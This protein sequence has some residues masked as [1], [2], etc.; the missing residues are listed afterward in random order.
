MRIL[1]FVSNKP[2]CIAP[3]SPYEDR[4]LAALATYHI[5]DTPLEAD[6]DDLARLAA[7][8]CDAPIAL[9]SLVDA[10]RQW[11]KAHYGLDTTETPREHAFCAHAILHPN[12]LMVVPDALADER[13]WDNP[14]VTGDPGIRFYAGTPLVTPAGDAV[15]VLCV[16]GHTPRSLTPLQADV[17]QTLGRQVLLLLEQRRAI[18]ELAAAEAAI[19]TASQRFQ[20]ILASLYGGILVV[21]DDQRVEF[22]NQAFCDLFNLA[23]GPEQLL[24]W[25]A[26]DI[27]QR[28]APIYSDT[29]A[30]LARIQAIVASGQPVRNEEVAITGG[31]TYLRDFIPIVLDGHPHG[32]AWHHLDITDRKEA[33]ATLQHAKEAA[34]AATQAKSAFL[35]SM[36]HEIRTPLNAVIGMAALLQ[37]TALTDEQRVFVDT[38]RTGGQALLAV[39]SDILDFSRIESG[40]LELESAP[41]DLHA[42][43]A[44][45]VDLVAP[46][47]RAEGAR[48]PLHACAGRAA[49]GRRRCRPAAPGAAQPARQRGEVHRPGRGQP[50]CV[51]RRAGRGGSLLTITVRDTGIGITADAD[52][53]ASSSPLC[54]PTA[55]WPAATAGPGLGLAIS[56]QLVALMG[57]TIG[58]VSTAGVGSTFR[59]RIPL[60]AGRSAALPRPAA[61]VAPA[62]QAAAGAR[63]RG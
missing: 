7:T 8:L 39:I 38:I 4:R 6:F 12:N 36:S 49:G 28:I 45:A 41:F 1:V 16:I 58:V 21:R 53:A 37:D 46:R 40:R 48:P 33:E 17:L 47:G 50:R 15:G 22:A 25:H 2:L 54:R 24:G 18:A 20:A 42:C 5:L 35:A 31:R 44:S 27:L 59:V 10:R 13:F 57:G 63:G 34:E 62:D 60:T 43:L 61:P 19:Q 11:F 55:R 3:P 14:L 32:R 56:R 30:A 23:E 26:S 52:R 51:Q 29:P 9:I